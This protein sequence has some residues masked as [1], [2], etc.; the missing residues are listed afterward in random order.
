M[1]LVK[2]VGGEFDE[3]FGMQFGGI[4]LGL[5]RDRQ[6]TADLSLYLFVIERSKPTDADSHSG[7]DR[8]GRLVANPGLH[9]HRREPFKSECNMN[10]EPCRV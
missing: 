9:F 6:I 8:V 2:E 3:E 7:Q 10:L 1:F 4:N 5:E